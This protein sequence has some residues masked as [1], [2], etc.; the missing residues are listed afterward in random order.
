MT[1]SVV[2]EREFGCFKIFG[3]D[4]LTNPF[5]R[6]SEHLT[7]QNKPNIIPSRIELELLFEMG[8]LLLVLLGLLE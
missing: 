6:I 7:P 5:N 4:P 1:S 3:T 2:G 8:G